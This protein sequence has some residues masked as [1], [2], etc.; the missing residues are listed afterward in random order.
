MM[1]CA[2]DRMGSGS[3]WAGARF[4]AGRVFGRWP[5]Q[6]PV[7][8]RLD[9]VR[10]GPPYKAARIKRYTPP[11]A[12]ELADFPTPP[13]SLTDNPAALEEHCE[14]APRGDPQTCAASLVRA[15]H[16]LYFLPLPQGQRSLRPTRFGAGFVCAESTGG[17]CGS[18]GCLRV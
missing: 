16:R 1:G 9:L 10:S 14:V 5:S 18:A 3:W 12:A 8:C 7:L 11:E 6:L 4:S 15:Q 13:E 17:N 2:S